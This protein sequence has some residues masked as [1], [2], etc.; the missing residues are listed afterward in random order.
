MYEIKPLTKG[1]AVDKEKLC[2]AYIKYKRKSLRNHGEYPLG[3]KVFREL[4]NSVVSKSASE[5]VSDNPNHF[6][7]MQD[8][9]NIIAFVSISTKSKDIVDVSYDYGEVKDFYVSPKHRRKGYGRVFN[10]YIE[11]VFIQNGT[12]VVL[13]SPDPVSGIDFWKAMGYSDTGIHQGWGK[14]FVYK[15]HIKENENSSEFDKVIESF[16]TPTDLISINPYNKKQINEVCFV[17]K[18][19]CGECNRKFRKKDV[20]KMAFCA[21]NSKGV[22]F[23]ALYFEGRII[24]FT[25]KDDNEVKYV[26]PEY[27]CFEKKLK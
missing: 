17:W 3:K 9:N 21:R 2:R 7:V 14:H 27:R 24:G 20:K 15:K 1:N 19:Y 8:I 6:I 25:Y 5:L 22:S 11:D 16:V 4:F 12:N 10:D 26:L 23:K 13:L 18:K